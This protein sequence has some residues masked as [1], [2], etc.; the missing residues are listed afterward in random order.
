MDKAISAANANR[1]FSQLLQGIRKGHSYIVTSHGKPV[2]KIVP[3]TESNRVAA[4]ARV[5]ALC[6]ATFSASG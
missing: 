4:G 2:A 5:C 6:Q 3:M 1:N